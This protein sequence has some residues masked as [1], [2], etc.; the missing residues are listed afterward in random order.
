MPALPCS[1]GSTFVVIV[2]KTTLNL[3]RTGACRRWFLQ[4]GK[5]VYLPHENN[6]HRA[7]ILG[8]AW[9]APGANL[10]DKR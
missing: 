5:P 9:F 3:P 10:P 2:I 6:F 4:L 1:K 7:A 8:T